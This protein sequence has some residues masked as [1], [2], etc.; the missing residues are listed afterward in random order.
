MAEK[1][2]ADDD[3]D[4]GNAYRLMETIARTLV[5][6]LPVAPATER[7]RTKPPLSI[8]N[9]I[10]R[11]EK[12]ACRGVESNRSLSAKSERSGGVEKSLFFRFFGGFGFDATY[13]STCLVLVTPPCHRNSVRWV[14]FLRPLG[15]SPKFFFAS[16]APSPRALSA[17]E[18]LF[19]SVWPRRRFFRPFGEHS[20][21]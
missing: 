5:R 14:E 4:T 12:D 7:P 3:N 19:S 10:V 17:P 1:T 16:V 18:T 6:P 11:L 21:G 13:N 8:S 9:A 15:P 2:D 20:V